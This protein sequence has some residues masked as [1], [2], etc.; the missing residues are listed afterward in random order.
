MALH[1]AKISC[2]SVLQAGHLHA[3]GGLGLLA[4]EDVVGDDPELTSVLGLG[5]LL[6]R[7]GVGDLLQLRAR[8][9]HVLLLALLPLLLLLALGDLVLPDLVVYLCYFSVVRLELAALKRCASA[10]LAATMNYTLVACWV[11]VHCLSMSA[12]V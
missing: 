11:V 8:A 10:V 4:A 9:Q 7:L 2:D 3:A 1:I 5:D 12:P 6:D